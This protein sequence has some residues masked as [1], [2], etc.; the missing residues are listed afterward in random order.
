MDYRLLPQVDGLEILADITAAWALICGELASSESGYN[1]DVERLVVGEASAGIYSKQMPKTSLSLL[2]PIQL[3]D[4]RAG[5]YLAY[6][7][8]AHFQPRPTAVVS[9]YRVSTFSHFF[10]PQER[11]SLG[12]PLLSKSYVLYNCS[13]IRMRVLARH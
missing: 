13:W 10:T 11:S 2:V 5:G 7:S 12:P 9:L 6:H 3:A 1:L 4:T 8:G